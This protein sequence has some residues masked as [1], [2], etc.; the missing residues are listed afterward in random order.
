MPLDPY[1]ATRMQSLVG[2]HWEDVRND[3]GRRRLEYYAVDPG[4]WRPPPVDVERDSVSGSGGSIPVRIY[5][6]GGP[7]RGLLVW[8]HGGGFAGGDLDM[9]ESDMVS[10]E[11]AHRASIVVVA[12]GY[13]LADAETLYPAPVDDA[14]AVWRWARGVIDPGTP[15]FL[16]GASAGAA[17]ALSAALR[18]RRTPMAPIGLLLAYPF[19]HFPVPAL[20]ESVREEMS[21]MPRMLRFDPPEIERMVRSYVGRLVDVPRAALPGAHALNGLPPAFIVVDEYDD[22]R[23]SA[24]LLETQL[25]ESGVPVERYLAR[26]MPHGHLNRSPAL[27]E[28]NA[29]LDMLAGFIAYQADRGLTTS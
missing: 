29:T 18:E 24:E 11:L 13:R 20:D 2:L 9:A 28:V 7:A 14:Q 8:L 26:G 1:L 25:V 17:I 6:A 15:M 5:R 16:G 23:P 27:P 22:L 10:R 21:M 12:V 19:A 4:E 3:E